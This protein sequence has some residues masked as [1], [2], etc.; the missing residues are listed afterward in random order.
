MTSVS[1]PAESPPRQ[2]RRTMIVQGA[3]TLVLGLVLI[4]APGHSLTL[5]ATLTGV[6][7]CATGVLGISRAAR[8]GLTR[9]QR[10]GG[11]LT[12]LLAL[13][14]GGV[15]IARPEGTIRALATVIGLYL[16]VTGVASAVLHVAGW[17]REASL[18]LALAAVVA[19]VVL[20]VWPDISAG[21][22]AVVTGV[23]LVAGG[24]LEL[25]AGMARAAE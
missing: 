25:W 21:A 1:D 6:A 20:L 15:A 22:F 12:G 5:V 11:V 7:L 13:V 9:P 23:F 18:P 4:V 3:V 17:M 8:A 19:G 16:V 10:V 24:A 2:L 14:A